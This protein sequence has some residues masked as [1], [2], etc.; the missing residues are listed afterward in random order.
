[1]VYLDPLWK[2]R[3]IVLGLGIN[4]FKLKLK[5]KKCKA[6]FSLN[7]IY[8]LGW[9]C[10]CLCCCAGFSLVVV[11]GSYSLAVVSGLLIAVASLVGHKL[12]GMKASV[13]VA[14]GLSSTGWVVLRHGNFPNQGS[15]PCLPHWQANSLPLSHQGNPCKTYLE[16]GWFEY[17][18]TVVGNS[19][20][21]RKLD[22]RLD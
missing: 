19:A 8:F 15:N 16:E 12:W 10:V 7:F 6:F 21:Y 9:G 20:C 1:M 13:V 17:N 4:Y 14:H 2:R 22:W 3:K 5:V 11:S 18:L